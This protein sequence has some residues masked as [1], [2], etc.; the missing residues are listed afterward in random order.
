MNANAPL[1]MCMCVCAC[2]HAGPQGWVRSIGVS[3]FGVGH[4]ERLAAGGASLP[5]VNQVGLAGRT[6][7]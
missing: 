7:V 3:N 6:V 2:M 1:R 4:L 5:A